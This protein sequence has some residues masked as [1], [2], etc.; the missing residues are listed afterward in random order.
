[1]S[2]ECTLSVGGDR[3]GVVPV[4]SGSFIAEQCVC[5]DFD[6]VCLENCCTN[7]T[8]ESDFTDCLGETTH[9]LNYS[10]ISVNRFFE[11]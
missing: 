11:W 3:V 5:M 2:T 1:M 9:T 10:Y 6:I 8:E 7:G 4:K